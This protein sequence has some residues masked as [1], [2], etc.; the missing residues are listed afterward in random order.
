MIKKKVCFI[1]PSLGAGGAERVVSFIAQNIDLEKIEPS[2]IVIGF[3]KDNVYDIKN[4]KLIFLEKSRVILSIP[5]LFVVL[6]KENPQV[7]LSAIRHLNTLM[8]LFSPFFRKTKFIGR[9]VN[10]SSVL[11]KYSQSKNNLKS[12]FLTRISYRFLDKIICQSNDMYEDVKQSFAIDDSKLIIINNPVTENFKLKEKKIIKENHVFQF[13]TVGRLAKQKGH[14]RIL[15]G[16]SKLDIPF[17]Y[18]I[19]GDG[20]EKENIIKLI[21]ELGLSSR[22]TLV[23]HSNDIPTYLSESDIFIQG[24]YVEGFPNALLE[25]S[26]VGTP[27]IA[28][29][30][31]G[32]IN[33]IVIEG[34]NG[35]IVA[36]IDNFVGKISQMVHS[37]TDWEPA[38][39]RK[40]VF[41]KFNQKTILTKYENLLLEI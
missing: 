38:T 16:L 37:L 4:V 34:V 1:L 29:D 10:V 14:Y 11:K 9:E 41:D 23:S 2:L 25:S 26:A 15:E 33:E 36:D 8:G 19:I 20:P 18:T 27:V 21:K 24:S 3:K 7:V 31:L 32:G 40:V 28:F 13:I 5:R 17:N 22:I 35:Y 12:S 39:V 6:K 30:A